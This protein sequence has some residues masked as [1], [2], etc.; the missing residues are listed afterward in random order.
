LTQLGISDKIC[1]T[2]GLLG[3]GA[4]FGFLALLGAMSL[5]GMMIKN[6]IMLLDEININLGEGMN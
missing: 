5:M 6:A 2:V 1:I 4:P 3:F